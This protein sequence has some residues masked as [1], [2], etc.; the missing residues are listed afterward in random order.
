MSEVFRGVMRPFIGTSLGAACV[1]PMRKELRPSLERALSGFAAG[2]MTA[3]GVWSLLIPAA[4]SAERL[5]MGRMAFLP[6]ALGLMAGMVLMMLLDR[7][8][9]R[10][11]KKAAE[12]PKNTMM[13]L[14]VTLHN[15][16]EGM[17]VGVAFAGVRCGGS[18]TAAAA[19]ALA[20][21]IAIQNFPEGAMVS[22]PLKA[23]GMTRRRAFVIGVLSGAVEPVGAAAA[24]L[25]AGT[26]TAA[27]PY[28]LSLAAG[29]MLYVA[30][31]ELVPEAALAPLGAPAFSAGFAV[32]M[33]LDLFFG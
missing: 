20:V 27:M 1:F 16:P 17:V 3:A 29:A 28:L 12:L 7:A 18:M 13:A 11:Y 9:K 19:M 25:A 4:E 33:S 21:G 31:A 22:M 5:G 10:L 32:M 30:A 23:E 26:V 24:F 2:V 8:V 14:A 15:I 6:A